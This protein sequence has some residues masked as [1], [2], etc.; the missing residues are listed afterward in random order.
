MIINLIKDLFLR[1]NKMVNKSQQEDLLSLGI[2]I[3]MLKDLLKLMIKT[4]KSIS[5]LIKIKTIKQSQS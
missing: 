5:L 4:R 2:N 3:F 1:I